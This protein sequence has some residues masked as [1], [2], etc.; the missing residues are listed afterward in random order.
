[1]IFIVCL[2]LYYHLI[3]LSRCGY[4]TLDWFNPATWLC[5]FQA[6]F[7]TPICRRLFHIQLFDMRGDCLFSWYWWNGWRPSLCLNN[8]NIQSN[9][10]MWSP[11]VNSQRYYKVTFSLSCHR[12]FHIKLTS[13][14]GLP[15]LWG[16]FVF[17]TNMSS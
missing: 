14:M 5:L 7:P 12:T 1:M 9:L 16:H 15:V 13:F 3:Q 8:T 10:P 4:G 2:Y 6:C 17:V 11:L